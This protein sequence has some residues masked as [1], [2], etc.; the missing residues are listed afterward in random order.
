MRGKLNGLSAAIAAAV[1]GSVATGDLYAQSSVVTAPLDRDERSWRTLAQ[2]DQGNS[3]EERIRRRMQA[4]TPMTVMPYE[5]AT[6][7]VKVAINKSH[8][9]EFPEGVQRVSIGNSDIADIL[10]VRSRQLYVVGKS[11]GSTNVVVWDANDRVQGVLNVEVTQDLAVLKAN[12]HQLLP[13]EPVEVRSSYGTIVLSGQVSSAPRMEA[14]LRLA[15]SFQSAQRSEK[16]PEVLNMMQV[17]GAQQVMLDVKVAEV[18]RTL[19][20]RLNI[21]FSA[22]G[23]DGSWKLGAVNGGAAF[24]DAVFD[25][26]SG[27][28]RIPIFTDP[29][30]IGPA[31]EEFAPNTPS[32]EN[33][34]I[35]ASR[36]TGNSVFNMVIDA[37]KNEG[38]ARILAEP[39][40]T[41]L[42]GQNAEFLAG[43]EFPIPV[44][45]GDGDVGIEFKEFGVELD[46]RPVVLDSGVINLDVDVS[47]S[48]LVT[49]NAI[50]V[51]FQ[52]DVSQ[53]F[54]I[55]SLVKRSASSTVE[56]ESGKTIAIAGMIDESL[57]ENVNKFPGLGELPIIGMLFR[58]QEYIKDQTELVIFVTP[59][60]AK[61]IAVERMRLPT[62]DFVE[63]TGLE[64]YLLGRHSMRRQDSG[65]ERDADRPA[66]L[67]SRLT[68]MGGGS[69]GRFG[70][71][72]GR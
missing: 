71:D 49:S 53:Q 65:E 20:K 6:V 10:V 39:N 28:A 50:A 44:P 19:I 63:P 70:H 41:T 34:G 37:A 18:S 4:T 2:N 42:T 36:L 30:P 33:A 35:F 56:L 43:G 40:L 51:G 14:A 24:P 32:I 61:P 45:S 67:E 72:L 62:D 59:R 69:E 68:A 55:P 9:L 1:L 8:V 48:D 21:Q 31:V 64:Y 11:I 12:L 57:R 25:S 38:L 5:G 27:D 47:V 26:L 66:S 22:F 17:G 52:T 15:N 29:T 60:L 46:F 16:A 7:P 58:S 54:F 3:M 13:G 23:A